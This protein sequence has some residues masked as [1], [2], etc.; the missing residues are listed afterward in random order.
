M[1]FLDVT[2]WTMKNVVIRIIASFVLGA[3]IG[4]DRGAKRRGGG[5]RTDAAVCVGAAIVMMT[6]QYMEVRYPGASDMARM[7]SQVVSGVGFLGAGS[8]L[9]TGHQVKGLTSAASIWICACVGLAVGI[10]FLDGAV[11]V[12][13]ILLAGLHM[14][15]WIE[16]KVYQHSRYVILCIE[17]VEGG[18]TTELL[19]RFRVDGCK[20]DVFEVDRSG[21]EMR[22]LTI[23]TT[24][25]IPAGWNKEEYIDSLMEII[26]ILSIDSM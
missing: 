18:V 1:F 23:S 20:V 19:R 9:V 6:G 16:E 25:R 14:L 22:S 13:G 3:L 17:A 7:A 2:A 15:P 4:I 8:I 12:T 26:G 11:L 5:A 24:I 10:G 21:T